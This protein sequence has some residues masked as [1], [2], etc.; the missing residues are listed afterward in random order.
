[1]TLKEQRIAY[2]AQLG[3]TNKEI[4]LSTGLDRGNINY[5]RKKLNLPTPKTV[6]GPR[7]QR[8]CRAYCR[9]CGHIRPHYAEYKYLWRCGNCGNEKEVTS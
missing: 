4:A 3:H 6:K 2:F 1:M 5:Y 8:Y 7:N 9:R